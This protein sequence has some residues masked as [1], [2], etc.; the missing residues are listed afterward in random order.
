[1]YKG[2]SA[3][4]CGSGSSLGIGGVG[5]FSVLGVM[6]GVVKVEVGVFVSLA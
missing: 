1:M 4:C 2:L 5:C 6:D 3:V